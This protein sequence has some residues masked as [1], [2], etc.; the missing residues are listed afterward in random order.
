[1]WRT[2]EL[3]LRGDKDAT[4]KHKQQADGQVTTQPNVQATIHESAHNKHLES[5]VDKGIK[6]DSDDEQQRSG[7]MICCGSS[8]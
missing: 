3:L 4:Y 8:S 7:R 1:M 5:A 2:G 6:H